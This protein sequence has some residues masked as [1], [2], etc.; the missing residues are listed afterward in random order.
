MEP[1]VLGELGGAGKLAHG[2]RKLTTLPEDLSSFSLAPG[3]PRY[4]YAYT[5]TYIINVS[6]GISATFQRLYPCPGVVNRKQ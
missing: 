1:Q 6:L 5:Q 2:L 4:T 3:V